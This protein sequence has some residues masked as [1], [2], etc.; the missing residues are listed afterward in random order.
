M[1]RF[2]VGAAVLGG[3]YTAPPPAAPP[4]PAHG[5][6]V[7]TP[8]RDYRGALADPVGFL[9]MDSELVVAVDGEQVRKS[10]LWTLADQKL[11]A[12]AGSGLTTFISMCG[13]DPIASV[14]GITMGLRGLKQDVPEG[15]IV[16]TGLSRTKIGDCFERA[17][18][19]G[20]SPVTV[21]HGVYTIRRDASDP[22]ALAF[23]FVDE[24]TLVVHLAPSATRASL[25]KVLAAGTPLRRS[26]A[27]TQLLAQVDTSAAVWG[28]ANGRSSVFDLTQG[29]QKPSA[30]WGSMQLDGGASV[31]MRMRFNDAS[32]AQ[33]L[34]T[35]VQSQITTAQMFFDR[36][37]VSAD[38][39]DLVVDVEMS[40][41]KLA[42]LLS[43]L[44][45]TT[46]TQPPPTPGLGGTTGP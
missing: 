46:P 24:A 26:P 6:P 44:G 39:A 8:S 27:F 29:N 45:M 33:Q 43:L 34:A 7:A 30:M 42:S 23:T 40:E 10:P 14:R 25:E 32:V 21:D 11:R 13:V 37:D 19:N 17:S 3:C 41:S 12:A 22:T 1:M 2:L 18:A 16:I 31:S 36:L 15:V 4:P 5:A 35:Q 9:P 28:I 20:P 38:G